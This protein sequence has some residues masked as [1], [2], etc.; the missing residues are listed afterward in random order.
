MIDCSKRALWG[1]QHKAD[2]AW[3][4]GCWCGP[5]WSVAR[6]FLGMFGLSTVL[7]EKCG[8]TLRAHGP[9]EL[10]VGVKGQIEPER[11][12]MYEVQWMLRAWPL[13]PCRI[14]LSG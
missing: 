8:K 14:A 1:E 10:A 2:Q 13:L 4:S 7:A 6:Q 5:S 3:G 9:G 12:D 11:L